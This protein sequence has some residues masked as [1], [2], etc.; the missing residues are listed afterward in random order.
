M[1]RMPRTAFA[2]LS[3][4]LALCLSLVLPAASAAAQT[5]SAPPEG[6][7][8]AATPSPTAP[9]GDIAREATALQEAWDLLLDRFVDPLEPA[10]LADAA[11]TAMLQALQDKGVQPAEGP[12]PAASGRSAI[13]A[14]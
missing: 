8:G 6:P 10:D 11:N 2:Q 12:L 3:L 14:G 13:W 9:S 4:V 7:A 5:P 1:T